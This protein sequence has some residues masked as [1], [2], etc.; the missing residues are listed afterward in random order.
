[1][2]VASGLVALLLVACG[3]PAATKQDVVARANAICGGTLSDLRANPPTAQG[4]TSLPALAAYLAHSLPI[5]EREVSSLRAL[6]RP[7]EDRA[8]L[9]SYVDAMTSSLSDYRSLAAAA[10]RGDEAGVGQA[11]ASLQ[12]SPASTLA[13][14]YGLTQ[15]AGSTSTAVPR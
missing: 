8:L 5:L 4:G 2:T 15:C 3:S 10:R 14:R 6:P 11:L 1:V 9:N 12:S 13:G 7:A